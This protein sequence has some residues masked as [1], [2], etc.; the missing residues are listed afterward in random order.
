M[1]PAEPPPEPISGPTAAIVPPAA[2][3][4]APKAGDA[5]REAS[6]TPVVSPDG[7]AAKPNSGIDIRALT[8]CWIQVRSGDDQA[9]VFS[10]VLKAGETYH[11]PRDGLLMRT[12]NAGALAVVVDGKPAPSLGGIGTLRRNIELNSEALL[13]GTAVKG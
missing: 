5:A 10:R 2:A 6:A 9:I 3:S 8:D 13:A 12:G 11:V 1:P 4:I 7:G